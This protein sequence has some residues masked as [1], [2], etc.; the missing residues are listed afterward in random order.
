MFKTLLMTTALS[1]PL[2]FNGAARR[3]LPADVQGV[4]AKPGRRIAEHRE[5]LQAVERGASGGG[6]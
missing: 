4:P 5:A 6:K 1:I 3:R 2:A